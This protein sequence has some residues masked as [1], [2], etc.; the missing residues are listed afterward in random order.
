M[1]RKTDAPRRKE[2]I[3]WL[4]RS[5]AGGGIGVAFMRINEIS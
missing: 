4:S 1:Q 2:K 3:Y 5:I